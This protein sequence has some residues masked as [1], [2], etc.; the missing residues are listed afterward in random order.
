MSLISLK[1]LC[2]KKEI[3]ELVDELSQSLG[4]PF[5]LKDLNGKMI[6]HQSHKCDA[7]GNVSPKNQYQIVLEGE[8]I[9]WVE[10]DGRV[11]AIAGLLELLARKELE[12]KALAQEVLDKYRELTLFYNISEKILEIVDPEKVANLV[13][14]EARKF[15]KATQG[16]VMLFDDSTGKLEAIAAFNF[17]LE[18]TT[19][20]RTDIPWKN[21]DFVYEV[22][23]LGRGEIVNDVASDA[24]FSGSQLPVNSM[25]CVPLKT[26][27][28]IIG[29]SALGSQTPVN[30]TAEDLKLMTTLASQ[31]AS[32]INALLHENK[33]K[34]S[35]R[36]ALLFRLASQIRLC[37]D[38]DSILTI[39]LKEIRKLLQ[40]DRCIFIW[41]I[42]ANFSPD[43]GKS[44]GVKNEEENVDFF[45]NWLVV[46][47]AIKPNIPEIIHHYA[48]DYLTFQITGWT[49]ELLGMKVIRIDD[50]SFIK[51][52]GIRE[53]LREQGL[54]SLLAVPLE[55]RSGKIGAIACQN[56]HNARPWSD[57]EVEL[58]QSVAIQLAIAL[59]QA[60]LYQQTQTAKEIAQAKAEELQ[61]ALEDLKKTEVQLIQSE[62]MS[63]LGQMVA[64]VAHE[65]NNPVNFIHGNLNYLQD[66]VKDL[67]E[68]VEMY[69]QAYPQPTLTIQKAIEDIDLHFL[70]ED[71]PQVLNSMRMGTERIQEIVQALRNFSRLDEAQMKSVDI[72]SGIESTL[73]ILRDRLKAK[74]GYPT[75]EVIK[76]YGNLP[77]IEC[78][79]GQL[80]QVFMNLLA[81]AIDAL[82]NAV[83]TGLIGERSP[84]IWIRT[85][86]SQANANP[87]IK[88]P[89]F[90]NAG[91]NGNQPGK[92]EP[93]DP[94]N[95]ER[96]IIRII[97]NG[98]GIPEELQK[99]LFD[100]FFTTKPVGKGTGLGL[101]ISYQIIVEKHRGKLECISTLGSGTEFVISLP[102][103]QTKPQATEGNLA[104]AKNRS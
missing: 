56:Y 68:L 40:I 54:W 101:S 75:I 33:L 4:I 18:Y 50:I 69:Q 102:V 20:Y 37:L 16:A 104:K 41:Y 74:P 17:D 3:I 32:A 73:L 79:A 26:K 59:D 87:Q 49:Q 66:Y 80:N 5:T 24:R 81:N 21:E 100:P 89:L 98:S 96:A 103:Q 36:E 86:L 63:S 61:K 28:K 12:K 34:E 85:E 48:P 38:G 6:I 7:G 35:R 57:D 97:D 45:S 53:L 2:S 82:E 22:A 44:Y 27:N 8:I 13:F 55:T 84:T 30:Y 42:P 72:H 60:E 92:Q 11:K 31:A 58:L 46:K 51:D 9:G 76:E 94:L 62:K 88:P 78:Y 77:K 10:G 14:E 70:I 25:I 83:E 1:K 29:T 64:G 52:A 67:L 91:Q 71:L 39:A 95:S 93:M 43:V 15:I 47:E 90:A 65:I 99:R 19:E 23:T